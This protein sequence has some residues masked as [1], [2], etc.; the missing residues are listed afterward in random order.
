MNRPRAKDGFPTEHR[1]DE[2]PTRDFPVLLMRHFCSNWFVRI[3]GNPFNFFL[4]FSNTLHDKGMS[5]CC[6]FGV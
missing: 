3:I 4:C 5:F 6:T 2:F 1:F